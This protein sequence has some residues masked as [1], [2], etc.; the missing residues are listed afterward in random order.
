VY[1]PVYPAPYLQA[2]VLRVDHP[3]GAVEYPPPYADL[4]D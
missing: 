4:P 3:R 1:H 2:L